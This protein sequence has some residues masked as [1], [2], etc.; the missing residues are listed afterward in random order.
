MYLQKG[1]CHADCQRVDAG[2]HCQRQ[3]GF[4]GEGAVHRFLF[5]AHRLADHVAADQRQQ[6]KGNP[7]I[8]ACDHRLKLFAHRISDQRHE[9]LKSAE[10]QT[11][12]HIMPRPQ[13]MHRKPLADRHG[14]GVHRKSDGNDNQIKHTHFFDNPFIYV[15]PFTVSHFSVLVNRQRIFLQGNRYHLQSL[16]A[17]RSTRKSRSSGTSVTRPIAAGTRAA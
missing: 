14:K 12:I 10:I 4:E 2:S 3:H 1:K 5:V 13:F 17:R 7:M 6:D 16:P 9:R 11:D 15:R 8:D